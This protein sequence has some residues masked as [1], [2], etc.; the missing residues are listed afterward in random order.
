MR[1][2]RQSSS[3]AVRCRSHSVTAVT[4]EP[5][6]VRRRRGGDGLRK[7]VAE[8]DAGDRRGHDR[9]RRSRAGARERAPAREDDEPLK[10]PA[11]VGQ[12]RRQTPTSAAGA[13]PNRTA[14]I[15]SGTSAPESST[16]VEIRMGRDSAA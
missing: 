14:A 9:R 10:R 16:L 12:H 13:G 15:T 11:P 6:G 7:Q 5:H 3:G 8:A 2:R 4:E 1:A